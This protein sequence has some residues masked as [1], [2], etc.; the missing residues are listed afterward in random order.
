MRSVVTKTGREKW[1]ILRI[2]LLPSQGK[3]YTWYQDHLWLQDRKALRA[4]NATHCRVYAGID[5]L[6]D[7]KQ[8]I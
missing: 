1:V 2:H 5:A 3:L 7:G 4:W 8:E 6:F